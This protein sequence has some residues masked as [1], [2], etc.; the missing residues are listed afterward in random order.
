MN[1][2]NIR[3]RWR[4]W[5]DQLSTAPGSA[6]M[7]LPAFHSATLGGTAIFANFHRKRAGSPRPRRFHSES[8][9][10]PWAF[11]MA[12]AFA[13]KPAMRASISALWSR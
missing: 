13:W 11:A 7:V 6:S 9:L 1:I 12:L 4:K 3:R 5:K 8:S 10:T 2:V